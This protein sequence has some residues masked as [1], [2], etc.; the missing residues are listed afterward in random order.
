[1]REA[2][3]IVAD[4]SKAIAY[5]SPDKFS[6]RSLLD[7]KSVKSYFDKVKKDGVGPDGIITKIDRI[8]KALN[9]MHLEVTD[10]ERSKDDIFR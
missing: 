1:M 5:C 8:N 10:F 6:W 3:Q 4:V 9:Y 7:Q 2:K